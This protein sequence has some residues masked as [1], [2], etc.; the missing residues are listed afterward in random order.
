MAE[1]EFNESDTL[2]EIQMPEEPLSTEE[3]VAWLTTAPIRVTHVPTGASAVGEGLGSQVKNKEK[4]IEL[5]RGELAR[6]G[7][8]S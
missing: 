7:Q 3:L 5:L 6:M 1:I 8:Q 2:T 4:A